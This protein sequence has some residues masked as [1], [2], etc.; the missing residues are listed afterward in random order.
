MNTAATLIRGAQNID[1]MK[2]EVH[3]VATALIGMLNG[4]RF[5][6]DGQNIFE[7]EFKIGG[8]RWCLEVKVMDLSRKSWAEK[9]CL[10]CSAADVGLAYST[11]EGQIPFRTSS[12][13]I[14]HESL[15]GLIEAIFEAYPK[16]RKQC[17]PF[18]KAATYEF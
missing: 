18:E 7:R 6:Y 13:Q 4:E 3:Q 17:E 12:V 14:V 1:R 15:S 5:P 9:A 2:K 11:R 10:S 16:V 8:C